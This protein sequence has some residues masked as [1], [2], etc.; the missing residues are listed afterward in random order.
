[1]ETKILLGKDAGAY[2]FDAST[3]QITITGLGLLHL[4]SLLLITNTTSNEKIYQFNDPALG[5]TISGTEGN[6]VVTLT[7]DTT[8]MADTDRLQIWVIDPKSVQTLTKKTVTA[9]S[10]GTNTIHTPA[11]GKKVRLYYLGYS[12][13]ATVTGVL[14]GMRFTAGGT[15]FDNQYLVTPGQPFGRNIQAGK[16]YIDGGTN[17]ALVVN[18]SAAQT[19]YVNIEI[20]EITP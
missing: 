2:S 15:D 20:E 16:R 1:M 6:Q 13:G 5:A 8:S 12:A 18:L 3:K 9:S 19:V 14:V 4:E 7:F 10:S 11:A 17:E